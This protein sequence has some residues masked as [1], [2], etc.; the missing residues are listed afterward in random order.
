LKRY[1]AA[2]GLWL[3]GVLTAAAAAWFFYRRVLELGEQELAA[4]LEGREN[5]SSEPGA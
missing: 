1:L 2:Y 3:A 4:E 5:G